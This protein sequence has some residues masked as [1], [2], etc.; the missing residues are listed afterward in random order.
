MSVK[1]FKMN[2]FLFS[3]TF[4]FSGIIAPCFGQWANEIDDMSKLFSVEQIRFKGIASCS[5]KL[6][7]RDEDYSSL[8]TPCYFGDE[9]F[10]EFDKNGEMTRCIYSGNKSSLVYYQVSV[11]FDD[12]QRMISK[13]YGTYYQQNDTLII[14][15]ILT[16]EYDVNRIKTKCIDVID[17]VGKI[18]TE[19][20]YDSSGIIR[21]SI[22]Q[23][24]PECAWQ[25]AFS[26]STYD[27][28]E[29]GKYL[30]EY[31]ICYDGKMYYE[32]TEYRESATNLLLTYE[33]FTVLQTFEYDE[34]GLIK[35]IHYDFKKRYDRWDYG[36]TTGLKR[37]D[38][39][40]VLDYEDIKLK[41]IYENSL[42]VS[43]IVCLGE[44]EKKIF[45]YQF[46][47]ELF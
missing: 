4:L 2:Q 27:Y 16:C 9:Q 13:K 22:Y 5:A 15:K 23:I 11:I 1:N 44:K 14:N 26:P 41:F 18:C 3:C 45:E 25:P 6:I 42:P 30:R 36:C 38:Y 34:I 47:Y 12:Q 10:F 24:C 33:D 21:D 29:D 8:Y 31:R 37:K 39:E 32:I 7:Y 19:F 40:T 17:G 28:N 46:S 20:F 35:S 43:M